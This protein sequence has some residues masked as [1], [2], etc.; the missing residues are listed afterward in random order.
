MEENLQLVENLKTLVR[1]AMLYAQHAHD[2]VFDE[3][4]D[5]S[6]ALSYLNIAAS[7]FSAA[8]SLYYS[9][10]EVLEHQEVE[11]IFHLFDVFMSELLTNVRTKHSHQWTDI[12][13][14]HLKDAFEYSVFSVENK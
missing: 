13:F 8:E 6:I 3:K 2:F 5:T 12:E 14:L 4:T 9:R 11:K 10:I 7:K 1:R